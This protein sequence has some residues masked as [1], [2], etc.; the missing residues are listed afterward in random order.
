M[1]R[2]IDDLRREFRGQAR[3]VIGNTKDAGFEMVPY[4]T[5][6]MPWDQA[7]LW[8]MTRGKT[9]IGRMC[10][11]LRS[12]GALYIANVIEAI[13][14]QYPGPGIT[15]HV[16][17]AVPGQSWHNWG[18]GLDCYLKIDG[19]IEWDGDHEGYAA[20]GTCAEDLGLTWGGRWDQPNDPGHIQAAPMSPVNFFEDITEL[21]GS[22]ERKYG[23]QLNA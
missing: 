11:S 19:A 23:G 20:Y 17:Y 1:S 22:L 13:G 3:A 15:G 6:R 18:E 12:N 16:T 14:P 21:S 5:L 4:F 7:V 8:R 2:N 9:E 10:R